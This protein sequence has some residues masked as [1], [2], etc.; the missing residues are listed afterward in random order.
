MYKV[1]TN[2]YLT[3]EKTTIVKKT[4]NNFVFAIAA[5]VVPKKT[6]IITNKP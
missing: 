1:E 6:P 4:T 3:K 5:N 2:G